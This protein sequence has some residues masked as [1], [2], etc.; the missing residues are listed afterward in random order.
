MTVEDLYKW[1]AWVENRP[2]KDIRLI[3]GMKHICH[4]DPRANLPIVGIK[5]LTTIVSKVTGKGGGE[6]EEEETQKT[7]MSKTIETMTLT[8]LLEIESFIETMSEMEW[9]KSIR[10]EIY[11]TVSWRITEWDSQAQQEQEMVE[12]YRNSQEME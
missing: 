8:E 12:K 3:T 1:V 7:K 9:G 11:N 4:E 5:H 2:E 6:E 10:K